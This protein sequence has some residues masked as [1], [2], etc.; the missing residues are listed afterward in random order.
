M[1]WVTADKPQDVAQ[2]A[3]IHANQMIT[4]CIIQPG[5][6]PSGLAVAVDAMFRSPP[7]ISWA[8]MP[9]LKRLITDNR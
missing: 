3:F 8:E 9:A 6:L 2:I 7:V 1:L 5:H 4:P